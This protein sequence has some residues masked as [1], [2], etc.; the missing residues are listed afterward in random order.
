MS[1]GGFEPTLAAIEQARGR[2]ADR[3]FVTPVWRW[4]SP[5]WAKAL[6]PRARVF[7]K[8]ELWQRTGSFKARAAL[9]A[10]LGL[11][12]D[13]RA[14]GVTAVSA[15]NH[16]LAV[17]WAA[18]Q[19]GTT[20]KVVMPAS[21]DAGRIAACRAGGAV[22]VLVEDV[23]Q[24]FATAQQIARDEGR[25]FIHPFESEDV[26]L[27]TGAIGLEILEQVEGVDDVVVPIGG[28]GLCAGIA[29]AVG[30]ARPTTRVHG[31]EPTGADSMHRSF[32]AGRPESI[33][34]V[35]TIADSLGSPR[36][37]PLTFGLCRRHLHSLVLVDDDALRAAMRVVHQGLK[38]AV[39]PAC[40]ATTAA[41]LGP[42]AEALQ[43]RTVVLVLCGSNSDVASVARHVASP[44]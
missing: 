21:A 39:E 14:R 32:A 37:E 17:A 30:L 26:V 41:A 27:S 34:A 13:A 12:D 10:V 31:V 22:V 6:G 16:A 36:A 25:R 19:A 3:V 7:V 8:L 9:H 2:L 29:A 42:L 28:G 24:A 11:D 15:G 5:M 44:A 1:A 23:H 33:E 38:L 20:A 35:R 40:A 4:D 18:Q 43:D